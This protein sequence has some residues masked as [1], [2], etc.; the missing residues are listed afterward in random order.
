MASLKNTVIDD[1]GFL[2]I[3]TGTTAE[4]TTA[5][6]GHI[7]YNTTTGQIEYHNGS[8]WNAT[9]LTNR[10][11]T[12]YYYEGREANLYTGN[13]NNSTIYTMQDFGGLGFVTAHGFSSGPVTFTLSLSSIPTHTQIRYCVLWLS[14]IHI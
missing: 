2:K 5:A 6:A 9:P 10:E 3:A 13:W 14:L 11:P 1:T 7:R 8:S 4:R 12:L